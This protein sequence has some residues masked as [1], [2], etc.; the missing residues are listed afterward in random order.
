MTSM[1]EDGGARMRCFSIRG[2]PF[3]THD[4]QMNTL[5]DELNTGLQLNYGHVGPLFV[6]WIQQHLDEVEQWKECMSG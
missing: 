6:Q 5:V 3:V 4:Q 1:S 2:N